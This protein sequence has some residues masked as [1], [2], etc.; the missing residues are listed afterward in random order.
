MLTNEPYCKVLPFCLNVS[1]ESMTTD[2]KKKKNDGNYQIMPNCHK[3]TRDTIPFIKTDITRGGREILGA[4]GEA[5]L[6]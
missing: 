3:L 1:K 6:V 4:A 2:K 5:N